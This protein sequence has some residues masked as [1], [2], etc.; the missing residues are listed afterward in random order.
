MVRRTK[1][2]HLLTPRLSNNALVLY[3]KSDGRL[4]FVIPAGKYSLVG[5]TD[6]DYKGDL[7]AVYADKTDVDYLIQEVQRVFPNLQ[8]KDIFYTYAGLRSLPDSGDEKPSNVSRAHKTIDHEKLDGVKGFISVLGGKIT[9]ARG[10]SEEI[11]NLVCKKLEIKAKCKTAGTPLPGAPMVTREELTKITT[12]TKTDFET[13]AYLSSLYGSRYLKVLDYAQ[14][15]ARGM[16][17]LCPHSKDITAQIWYAVAEESTYTVS[18]FM[19]RRSGLGLAECQ[20]LDAVEIVGREMGKL[21]NWKPDEQKQQVNEYKS[22][23]ALA[24]KYKT[25]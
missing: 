2:V 8:T 10:I 9:G 11:T 13:L 1:G 5:T 12:E 14:R 22:T 15:G 25:A 7:E 20:G 19:M 21:L 18:D 4:W 3:A 23:A 24:Q 6:T 16:Q 17:P